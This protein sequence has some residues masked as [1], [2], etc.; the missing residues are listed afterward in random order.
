MPFSQSSVFHFPQSSIL[1]RYIAL[2]Y[3]CMQERK[4]YFYTTFIILILILIINATHNA[5]QCMQSILYPSLPCRNE[6]PT[7]DMLR[8]VQR[9]QT[10][11]YVVRAAN[12][13]QSSVPI[14]GTY[15]WIQLSQDVILHSRAPSPISNLRR[16]S[17]HSVYM[18]MVARLASLWPGPRLAGRASAKSR[19]M[20]GWGVVR[21]VGFLLVIFWGGD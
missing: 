1:I 14:A 17:F 8:L 6:K 5:P 11:K 19:H 9:S 4:V 2:F 18:S 20:P 7:H 21:L 12:R 15:R 13:S 16:S 3:S 10:V